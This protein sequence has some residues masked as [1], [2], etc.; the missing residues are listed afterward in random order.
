[1][2]VYTSHRRPG[3]PPLLVREGFSW[4]GAI[5]GWL[6]FLAHAA[7]IPAVLDLA[8][9]V[10]VWRLGAWLRSPWPGVGLFLLQGFFARDLWCWSLARRGFEPGPV[11]AAEDEET[12]FARL[13]TEPAA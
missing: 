2:R 7:W 5:F 13:M 11:V 4:L 6:W 8:L 12:A 1:M 3:E 10:L 9:A